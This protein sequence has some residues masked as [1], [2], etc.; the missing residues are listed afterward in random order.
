MG[1]TWSAIAV[2]TGR[3]ETLM[4]APEQIG[5]ALDESFDEDE[6]AGRVAYLDKAWHAIHFVLTQS[7][8][9]GEAPWSWVIFGGSPVV[10]DPD[11]DNAL[12]HLPAE[13]VR[14]VAAALATLPVDE[15]ADRY[16][17]QSLTDADIYP[18]AI[19]LR[20][21]EDAKAYVLAYYAELIAF[22]AG[23][24]ARGDSV[25]ASVG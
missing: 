16:D 4:Q 5:E 18:E 3:A 11:D 7:A 21:G 9:E 20:D 6:A 22:Y 10:E 15:F 8:W 13:Q 25:F 2:E 14:Q 19:W 12:R 17:A 24:A 23:A 1:M